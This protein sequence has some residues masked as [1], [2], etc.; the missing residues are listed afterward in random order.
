MKKTITLWATLLLVA[1]CSQAVLT[2]PRPVNLPSV[3]LPERTPVEVGQRLKIGAPVQQAP[4]RN[5]EDDD[6][7]VY[8]Y[9]CFSTVGDMHGWY[10]FTAKY[11]SDLTM[12]KSFGNKAGDYGICSATVAK[13][14]RT[15]AYIYQH[16]GTD[17][18]GWNDIQMPIGIAELDYATGEYE[19]KF[20]TTTFHGFEYNVLFYDMAYDPVTDKI[21][22]C[23]FA[24]DVVG[25]EVVDTGMMNIYTIDPET[26]VPTFIGRADNIFTAMAADNG[27][28]Y[29]FTHDYDEEYSV[30]VTS[31]VKFD[32]TQKEDGIFKTEKVCKIHGG[33]NIAYTVQTMEFDLTTHKLYWMGHRA[34]NE[35]TYQGVIAEINLKNG[36]FI[37]EANIPYNIQYFGLAIPYQLVADNA[38]ASVTNF[39]VTPGA[40]GANEAIISWTNPTQTYQLEN[41]AELTG[42]KIYRDGELIGTVP[43]TELGAGISTTDTDVP[44][45]NHTY[46]LVPYNSAGDGISKEYSTFVGQDV[47]SSIYALTAN[48]NHDKV[49]ISWAAPTVGVN[50]GWINTAELRYTVYRGSYKIA[51][52]ITE[53]IIEDTSNEYKA[54]EYHV[55]PSTDAGDGTP[56]SIVVAY[57]PAVEL[58]Y[59]NELDSEERAAELIVVDND[60]NG[61]S[62]EYS[63]GYQGYVYSTS[64]AG[65]ML[66]DDYLVLPHMDLA[67]GTKYQIRFYYYTGNY[68]ADAY[69]KLQ[70]VVGKGQRPQDLTTVVKDFS[71]KADMA[72]GAQWHE[73]YTEY[74][75]T[76]D[77]LQNFAFKCKTEAEVGFIILSWFEIREVGTHEAEAFDITGPSE[78]Y[79]GETAEFTVKVRNVGSAN[80]ESADVK[81]LNVDGKVVAQL[82]IENLGVDE[83]RDVIVPWTPETEGSYDIYGVIRVAGGQDDY[84]WDDVTAKHIFVRVNSADSD[85]WVV[86]GEDKPEIYDDRAV[87]CLDRKYA[88]SQTYYYPDELGGEDLKIT[89]IR[90]HYSASKD[91]EL[92]TEV[93]VVIRMYNTDRDALVDG[94][95]APNYVDY[96]ETFEDQD[97]MTVVFDGVVAL[98]G[99]SNVTNVLEI[100]LDKVFEYDS[101]KNL[102]VEF[103][104]VWDETYA[105]VLWHMDI[106]P[107]YADRYSAYKDYWGDYIPYGRCGFFNY[108]N[109]YETELWSTSTD[110]FP[111][112]KFS[113][114]KNNS[115]EGVEIVANININ[116]IDNTIC[117]SKVC[118]LAELYDIAGNK[119]AS[120]KN[121]NTLAT[122]NIP[123]GIYVVKAVADGEIVTKKVMIK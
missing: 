111:H 28:V 34:L 3:S 18:G 97:N 49:T 53:T 43:T 21:Y 9:R 56:S 120:A 116:V 64:M 95:Y 52:K 36:K 45:A 39:T 92:L 113:Y 96:D 17:T 31:V 105:N 6:V 117:F 79:V 65:G 59:I 118:E 63:S 119:V 106:N 123:A 114:I 84:D 16:Y 71:F 104:K 77:G 107:K 78:T 38:P 50:G 87:F 44:S 14:G 102:L 74:L 100:K 94:G 29:G 22:A 40:N 83:Q 23:E 33:D 98:T 109:P 11:P 41:L 7:E 112:I 75:A 58:P 70:I 72:N 27:M 66:G 57:G 2:L 101:S 32:P 47:P 76:E 81:L 80:I 19:V 62:W 99:S 55:V 110:Y 88:R 67:A 108:W 20:S 90:L 86:I 103:D 122:D 115:V 82:P 61:V 1:F 121:V 48:V 15:Y 5:L 25:S 24:Y 42:V 89:G 30:Q 91:Y 54:Y 35:T 68:A 69:E 37:N 10:N 26:C 60:R 8:A 12:V 73:V 4:T 93:P 46:R 51:D 85:A 13:D